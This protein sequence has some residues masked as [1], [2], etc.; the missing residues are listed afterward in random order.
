MAEAILMAISINQRKTTAGNTKHQEEL[1]F[2]FINV[3][4]IDSHIEKIHF[5]FR[6][7]FRS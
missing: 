7:A 2:S 4:K 3:I 5:S 6:L 1:R